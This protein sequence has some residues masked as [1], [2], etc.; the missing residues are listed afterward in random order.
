MV[1]FMRYD[2]ERSNCSR[3]H[4]RPRRD[5]VWQELLINAAKQKRWLVSNCTM[6]WLSQAGCV[7]LPHDVLRTDNTP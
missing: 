7:H 1:S 6:L 5:L 3:W 4:L 2:V